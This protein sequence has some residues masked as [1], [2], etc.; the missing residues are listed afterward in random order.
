MAMK[1]K[2]T[3]PVPGQPKAKATKSSG[4]GYSAAKGPVI[5]SK[6]V[7]KAVPN[8]VDGGSDSD[9]FAGFGSDD[10]QNESEMSMDDLEEEEFEMSEQ[11]EGVEDEEEEE[12]D[13]IAAKEQLRKKKITQSS[14]S[15]NVRPESLN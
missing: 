13:E 3:G 6:K 9:E 10:V 1:R 15:G 2:S 12:E 11:G 5:P 14:K 7:E 4:K 8:E